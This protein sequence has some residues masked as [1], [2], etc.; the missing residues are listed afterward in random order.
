MHEKSVYI[1]AEIGVNHNGSLKLAL[2]SIDAAKVAGADAVKF[3][4]FKTDRLTTRKAE[5][6]TYQRANTKKD[7]SQYDMLSRLELS[8]SDFKEIKDYCDKLGIGFLSTPFDAESASFLKKIGINGFKIGSG[9][10]NNLPFLRKLDMYG[11]PILLS[12]GMST[13]EEVIEATKCFINSP[14]TILHCTSNY[15][16]DLEDINLMAMN[17]MRDT[18]G[19]PIGYSDHSLGYDVA[20]CAVAMGAK[21][22]EKHFTLDKKLPGPDHKASLDPVEFSEFTH[23][24]RNTELFLGDGIKRPMP[25]EKNT[26]KVARKSVVLIEDIESGNIITEKDIGIKRPGTGIP[27]KY[28]YEVI[29]KKATRNLSKDDVLK[30][31]DIE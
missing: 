21:V 8:E 28:Y 31:E 5:M 23:H 29:G 7:E 15:P 27:P 4:T 16:A 12:T 20:I 6:A 13:L 14:I 2:K 11:L 19:L 3:Q 24:I 22:I 18:I 1:I 25:S 17:T 10:L 30:E 26:R 9:D